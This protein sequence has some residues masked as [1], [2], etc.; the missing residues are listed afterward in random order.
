MLR[1]RI[2]VAAARGGNRIVVTPTYTPDDQQLIPRT[3]KETRVKLGASV[4]TLATLNFIHD[5]QRPKARIPF[6]MSMTLFAPHEAPLVTISLYYEKRDNN[7]TAKNILTGSSFGLQRVSDLDAP[8]RYDA[9][10]MLTAES[11]KVTTDELV[12]LAQHRGSMRS[13]PEGLAAGESWE[14]NF[15]TRTRTPAGSPALVITAGNYEGPQVPC[16]V[17]GQRSVFVNQ[18][19]YHL[20]RNYGHFR[21]R[22]PGCR[23]RDRSC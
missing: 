6:V 21:N 12:W 20:H 1:A 14:S 15:T 10:Q 22:R 4:D 11:E 2:P 8:L 13:S 18:Q 9:A 23:A 19:S 17:I 16:T 7:G 5:L 3:W